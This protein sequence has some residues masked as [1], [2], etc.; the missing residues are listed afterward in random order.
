MSA[1]LKGK[2]WRSD[3]YI[4][5]TG[6]QLV[7]VSVEKI[8]EYDPWESYWEWVGDW[9]N[10]QPPYIGLFDLLRDAALTKT[11]SLGSL[12]DA[13]RGDGTPL[14]RMN[15]EGMFEPILDWCSKHGVLGILP[16]TLKTIEYTQGEGDN[17][18]KLIQQR[19]G[20][21]WET[22]I[23]KNE[24]DELNIEVTPLDFGDSVPPKLPRGDWHF[25]G[26]DK[27][28]SLLRSPQRENQKI[29]KNDLD[30]FIAKE[31]K[32]L[33]K[34]DIF[35][36][37][38]SR[39]FWNIYGDPVLSFFTGA[40]LLYSCLRDVLDNLDLP[41]RKA[42]SVRKLNI[43]AEP[44]THTVEPLP[45]GSRSCELS[46]PSLLSTFATMIV[47]DLA[48]EN[49]LLSCIECERIFASGTSKATYCS[50]TCR[51]RYNRRLYRKRQKENQDQS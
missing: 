42:L 49:R 25:V 38:L 17:Q 48:S 31:H 24:D 36:V 41:E 27:G 32:A 46:A 50:S 1:Q 10:N 35:P 44:V 14:Q 29:D 23:I 51:N 19:V 33:W 22:L 30:R 12:L 43:L 37:P 21:R 45:D 9:R 13:A 2:W 3:R 20:G 18:V 6:G 11:V 34:S 4:V 47:M 39:A 26:G 28:S 7:P 15:Q 40:N 16:H 8:E 5:G